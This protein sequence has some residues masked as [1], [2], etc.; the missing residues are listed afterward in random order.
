MW[1]DEKSREF[2][3]KRNRR[4]A[5]ILGVYMDRLYELDFNEKRS[6]RQR[7]CHAISC[8]VCVSY[9]VWIVCVKWGVYYIPGI[10]QYFYRGYVLIWYIENEGK[11]IRKKQ[12]KAVRVTS[13]RRVL[14]EMLA[15][16]ARTTDGNRSNKKINNGKMLHLLG[17]C[18]CR[19]MEENREREREIAKH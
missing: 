13:N 10:I 11:T 9:F 5:N 8:I 18:C 15:L 19:C 16:L 1:W 2:E 14:L 12:Q 7:R 6:Q 3:R 4:S 17:Y